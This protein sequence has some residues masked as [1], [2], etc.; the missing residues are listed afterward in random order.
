MSFISIKKADIHKRVLQSVS[1][2]ASQNQNFDCL[3]TIFRFSYWMERECSG[4]GGVLHIIDGGGDVPLDRVMIFTVINIAT[5]YLNRP[6]WLLAGYSVYH[7]V[8]SRTSQLGSQPTMFMTGPRSRHQQ[9]CVRDTTDFKFF[10][11]IYCKTTIGQGISEV[12]NIATGYA[13]ESF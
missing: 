1:R 9:R 2:H 6:D 5:G 11:S 12:C 4:G 10:M 8:A 7:R 3:M 13:Y